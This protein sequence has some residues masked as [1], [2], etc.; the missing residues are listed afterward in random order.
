MTMVSEAAYGCTAFQ[1]A[2]LLA[3]WVG[4]GKALTP[5]GLLRRPDLPDAA[6]AMGVRAPQR[7]RSAADLPQV[8]IPWTV[9]LTAGLLAVEGRSVR[10]VDAP[11]AP[12]AVEESVPT[13]WLD[14]FVDAFRAMVR[15]ADPVEALGLAIRLLAIVDGHKHPQQQLMDAL[16]YPWLPGE[17][18]GVELARALRAPW[19]RAE[20][21]LD[22]LD[23]FGALAPDDGGAPQLSPLGKAVLPV[24]RR[25]LPRQ[26]TPALP[27]YELLALLTERDEEDPW[28]AAYPWLAVRPPADAVAALLTAAAK[29]GARQRR[30][31]LDLIAGL[32]EAADST[33]ADFQDHPSIGALVRLH[34]GMGAPEAP[35]PN[36]ADV[37]WLQ[38][39]E[40]VEL[41][42]T[43]GP[44]DAYPQMWQQFPG[45]TLEEKLAEVRATGHPQAEWL[46]THLAAVAAAGQGHTTEPVYQLKISLARWRPAVWRRLQLPASATLED[47]HLAVQALLDWDGD[48]LHVFGVGKRQ[49]A[50]VFH[51]LEATRPEHRMRLD[52]AFEIAGKKIG[53]VY[54]LGAHWAHEIELERILDQPAP[55]VGYPRCTG[56]SGDDPIEYEAYEYEGE[57]PPQAVPFD[58]HRINQRLTAAF[59][60]CRQRTTFTL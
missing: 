10:A 14:A 2:R 22:V 23:A 55:G 8:H 25:R 40:I 21:L 15:D 20:T 29:T 44:K 59:A 57:E 53:Y 12:Q 36:E 54:D 60:P 7:V 34:L 51:G 24:L 27:A 47:V 6:A 56:G 48:H 11:A 31:A 13:V 17:E 41:A 19:D 37:R 58:L 38:V 33:L 43:R 50:D 18:P 16:Q 39:E 3:R 32:G 45:H 5:G 28:H 4:G 46:A 52:A 42:E 49:Y 35:E 9:A 30:C 1:Q 26:I